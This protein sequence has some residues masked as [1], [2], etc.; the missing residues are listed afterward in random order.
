VFDLKAAG[1]TDPLLV[2]GTDGVG[3]KLRI[4]IDAGIHDTVGTQPPAPRAA[5]ML[6]SDW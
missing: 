4:A 2:S 6:S 1:Y 3:T 5:S